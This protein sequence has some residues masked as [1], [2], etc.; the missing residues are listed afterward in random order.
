MKA[1]IFLIGVYLTLFIS[2]PLNAQWTWSNPQP[3]G[4]D[5]NVILFVDQE[6]GIILND[7]EIL[8][9]DNGGTSWKIIKEIDNMKAI[10]FANDFGAIICRWGEFFISED[11]GLTWTKKE[12]PDVPFD[13]RFNSIKVFSKDTIVLSAMNFIMRTNNGGKNWELITSN[14][15]KCIKTFFI[16][17][18]LGHAICGYWE[19]KILKTENGGLT[20]ETTYLPDHGDLINLYF[21]NEQIGFVSS[22]YYGVLKTIDGGKNWFNP[23]DNNLQYIYDFEF[24]SEDIGYAGGNYG[25][26]YKTLDGG[27]NWFKSGFQDLLIGDSDIHSITFTDNQT[28]YAVGMHGRIY[29][30][31]NSAESWEPYSVSYWHIGSLSF[32]SDSIGYATSSTNLLK[33]SDGGIHWNKLGIELSSSVSKLQFIDNNLGYW[34]EKNMF[35]KQ[36]L[37]KT[38]DG[39]L[40]KQE[41]DLGFEYE[42]VASFY[43]VNAEIGFLV[44]NNTYDI[45]KKG[46][47]KT[48][49]GGL[50]WW[51]VNDDTKF[52][53]YKF[54]DSFTGFSFKSVGVWNHSL[55]KT[56]DAGQ[57]WEMIYE[58]PYNDELRDYYFVDKKLGYVTGA[59]L[60]YAKTTD[61]GKT[62][63]DESGGSSP[64]FIRF[65]DENNGMVFYYGGQIYSTTN[66]GYTWDYTEING[67]DDFLHC[68]LTPGGFIYAAGTYGS[69]ISNNLISLSTEENWVENQ[70][71]AG[72]LIYPNPAVD[73]ISVNVYYPDQTAE[74]K[75]FD[76]QGRVIDVIRNYNGEKIDLGKLKDG[77]Y[78]LS[79]QQNG[80][81]RVEK[82]IVR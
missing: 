37:Y 31:T 26:I 49:D 1:F 14:L 18:N 82:L 28:G 33:T 58:N 22:D 69:I 65:S 10:D 40:S 41:V 76:M 73:K 52:Y 29:K 43:F 45:E 77:A 36:R 67:Y 53:N 79:I 3:S 81:T 39:A 15:E 7:F 51:K 24:I 5:N 60:K 38:E 9:S 46:L 35:D 11:K 80:E 54:L 19:P 70:L 75:I 62:W 8:R 55:F 61:G 25:Q 23:T 21:Y 78:F 30:T 20:W 6:V 56:I 17:P 44:I 57:T 2:F 74:V 71:D 12:I 68:E 42:E 64:A 32:P 63:V 72:N 48:I 47:Y 16:N 27:V 13:P 4:A 66:G 34:I 50:N 59:Y